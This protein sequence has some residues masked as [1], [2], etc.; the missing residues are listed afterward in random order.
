[1]PAQAKPDPLSSPRDFFAGQ[2]GLWQSVRRD[3]PIFK[4]IYQHAIQASDLLRELCVAQ[5]LAP[6]RRAVLAT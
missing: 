1:M 6:G 2:S 3:S 5:V 4:A